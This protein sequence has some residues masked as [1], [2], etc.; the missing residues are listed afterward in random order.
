MSLRSKSGMARCLQECREM[1][2]KL[3]EYVTGDCWLQIT[4]NVFAFTKLFLS[5]LDDCL[6]LKTSELL[7]TI[8]EILCD[9]F[10]AQVK[11]VE[12]SL[13]NE[14]QQEVMYYEGQFEMFGFGE[15][16]LF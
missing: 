3:E 1:G 10:E 9:V 6:K 14:K 8:D 12:Q 15:R 16:D 4:S 2:L 5:L 13:K 11:Y 7:H